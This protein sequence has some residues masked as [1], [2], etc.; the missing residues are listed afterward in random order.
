MDAGTIGPATDSRIRSFAEN[1][2]AHV[3]EPADDSVYCKETNMVFLNGK[4]SGSS[5]F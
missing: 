3:A 4:W 5:V 1:V 2:E